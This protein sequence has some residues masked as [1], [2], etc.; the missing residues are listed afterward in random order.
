MGQV[1]T[2]AKIENFDDLSDLR[3]G[4]IPADQVRT[5]EVNNALVDTGATGLSMPRALIERLGLVPVRQRNARISAGPVVVQVFEA[6]RL[7]IK[8]RVCLTEVAELPDDCPIL[9]G[10]IPLE[11][12]DF[13]VD[14]ISHQLIGNP[15]HG[16]EHIMELY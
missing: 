14:P 2:A 6:V 9:I 10:Q 8:D 11:N 12:L 3:R 13:V 4:R 7:T 16:G 5:I 1:L 15:A